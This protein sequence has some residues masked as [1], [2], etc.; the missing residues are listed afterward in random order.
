MGT[1]WNCAL[2]TTLNIKEIIKELQSKEYVIESPKY[3]L[4]CLSYYN[5]KF[6]EYLK[7]NKNI[8]IFSIQRVQ[9]FLEM[10]HYYLDDIEHIKTT[11][12]PVELVPDLYNII[13]ENNSNYSLIFK[14]DN[15]FNYMYLNISQEI[16][17]G[18]EALGYKYD[19]NIC[20]VYF[21]LSERN[22]ILINCMLYHEIGH[23]IDEILKLKEK[24]K[25]NLSIITI[26]EISSYYD[27]IKGTFSNLIT[28]ETTK[29]SKLAEELNEILKSWI[30]EIIADL[31]AFHYIGIAYLLSLVE[32]TLVKEGYNYYSDSH[33]PLF[34]RLNF[35]F[36]LYNEQQYDKKIIKFKNLLKLINEYKQS[37]D[38]SFKKA[39]KIPIFFKAQVL[40]SKILGA[41]KN[42]LNILDK[43]LKIDKRY[44][45]SNYI[46]DA[47]KSY[48]NLIPPIEYIDIVNKKRTCHS[49]FTIL[50][51]AWIVKINYED[52]I[53]NKFED[54]DEYR[55]S[56]NKLAS[57][58][59]D[60]VSFVK[61]MEK[62]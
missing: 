33:P 44:W 24:I 8:S 6:Y 13:K 25:P 56:I 36:K 37:T 5:N 17:E 46:K 2:D 43:N 27:E 39:I 4:K 16:I 26:E 50:N 59:L 12:V 11:N 3:Y 53:K 19:K 1:S 22:N 40:E 61:W 15:D 38:Y 48:L 29:K 52:K 31:I 20:V 41:S 51:A 55:N 7:N 45:F 30:N 62:N 28:N 47:V 54:E 57:K 10:I 34:L 23:H 21:P 18:C 60:S 42:I 35:L 58:A 49:P 9:I 14:P 32:L